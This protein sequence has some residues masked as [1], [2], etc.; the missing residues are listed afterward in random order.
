MWNEKLKKDS[1]AC[2]KEIEERKEKEHWMGGEG[3]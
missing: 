1:V 2:L 3:N